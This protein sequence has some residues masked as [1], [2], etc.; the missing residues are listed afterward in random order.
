MSVLFKLSS[1]FYSPLLK[2]KYFY[3]FI[4]STV[5]KVSYTIIQINF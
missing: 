2:Y 1:V 5:K 3:S 4:E